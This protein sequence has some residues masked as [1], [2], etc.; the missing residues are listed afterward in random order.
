[1]FTIPHSY[2]GR[3]L[4]G[5]TADSS[6][7]KGKG[8]TLWEVQVWMWRYGRSLP[9]NVTIA[10][11][12][13]RRAERLHDQRK[14]AAATRK[15]RVER[16]TLPRCVLRLSSGQGR[17]LPAVACQRV[18]HGL[19]KGRLKLHA[20]PLCVSV[21]TSEPLFLSRAQ[22]PDSARVRRRPLDEGARG[23]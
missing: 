15:R 12:A 23:A 8:T 21:G 13:A 2:R 11:A 16:E 10:K 17:R 7:G 4:G 22:A 6:P 1:M 5:A 14:R 18:R 9:W 20:P 3:D 19:V